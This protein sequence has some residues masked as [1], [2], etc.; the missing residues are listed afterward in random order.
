MQSKHER[1]R[2]FLRKH[3]GLIQVSVTVVLKYFKE[4]RSDLFS[5]IDRILGNEVVIV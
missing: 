5:Y 2:G 3:L 1:R 4:E